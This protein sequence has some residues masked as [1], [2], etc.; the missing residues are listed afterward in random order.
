[1]AHFDPLILRCQLAIV[2]NHCLRSERRG[3]REKRRHESEFLQLQIFESESLRAEARSVRE[4]LARRRSDGR[5]GLVY[6]ACCVQ[7]FAEDDDG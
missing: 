7:L 2:E 1:M 6:P 5:R 4:E 3:L